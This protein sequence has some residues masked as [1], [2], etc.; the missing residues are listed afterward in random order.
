VDLL[1]R[2]RWPVLGVVATFVALMTTA[3]GGRT[4]TTPTA[5]V[6]PGTAV[7]VTAAD[8]IGWSQSAP[9]RRELDSYK[10]GVYV[11]GVR[12]L[13]PNATCTA[14][15]P[16]SSTCTSPLPSLTA[17]HHAL[18]LVAIVQSLFGTSESPRSAELDVIMGSGS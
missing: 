17:G 18:A 10:Y 7:Q 16:T 9:T 11:D 15:G 8:R 5:T 6:S 13:L 3:C 2:N 12:V 4:P 14:T 1:L